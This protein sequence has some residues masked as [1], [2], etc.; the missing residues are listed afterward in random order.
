VHATPVSGTTRS[1]W[2]ALY[3]LCAGVLMIVLDVTVVN[4]ALPSIQSELHF[5]PA[6]LAWVVN[7]YLIPFAGLLL[8][9]GRLG[10]LLGRRAIV[11]SGL[12]LFTGASVACGLAQSEATLVAARA[13]QGAGGA[14]TSAVVLG[15][16]VGLFPDPNDQ[17][18]AMGVYGF[19]A[20]AGGAIGLLAGGVLTQAINWHWIFFVNVPIGA[21]TAW[22][23]AR[24]IPADR[25]SG[26][27]SGADVLG[28]AVVTA[29]LMAAVYTL[30][31]PASSK[32]WGSG[33]TIAWA[34]GALVLGAAFVAR[35]ATAR[36]PLVPLRVL[37]TRNFATAN[38]LQT[39]TTAGMF[40]TFFMGSLYLQQVLHYDPVQI[41]LAFF[42]NTVVMSVLSLRGAGWIARRFGAR[43]PL[44][45][46]AVLT[47]ASLALL[48]RVP[49]N[50]HY[51]TDVLPAL[52]LIG[53]GMGIFFPALMSVAM[54]DATPATAGLASGVINTTA[55]A[56]GALGLAV[57]ATVAAARTAGATAGGR[58]VAEALTGGFRLAFL[59]A[60][61][62]MV[63][64]VAVAWMVP[65]RPSRVPGTSEPAETADAAGDG[66][67]AYAGH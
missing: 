29:A 6:G 2:L 67:P 19:V 15:M 38:V 39:L 50:G 30:V 61:G 46:G 31:G 36:T 35:E 60:A 47:V 58:P 55:E 28:A 51:V 45:T 48:A 18:K 17:A 3:V 5:S 10:D 53:V 64:A 65:G 62:L 43:P 66:V 12:V 56:G 54:A 44:V 27:R 14:M 22:A 42:P 52:L 16:I 40:G 34:V 26:W 1:P 41:G 23:I 33:T 24:L 49:A 59:V 57:L 11:L 13:V 4:V 25:G 32:G 37:T 9:A 8:L 20:S 63:I 21:A 7:A